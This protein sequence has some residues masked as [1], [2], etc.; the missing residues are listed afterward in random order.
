M[1]R[2]QVIVMN[3]IID[4]STASGWDISELISRINEQAEEDYELFGNY[5]YDRGRFCQRMVKYEPDTSHSFGA[6]P[7]D[8]PAYKRAQDALNEQ[9]RARIDN[10]KSETKHKLVMPPID[11]FCTENETGH[12]FDKHNICKYCLITRYELKDDN[13]QT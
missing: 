6:S 4:N 2:L 1:K 10:D 11:D 7:I 12:D 9:V 13:E 5:Y 3:K 8:A